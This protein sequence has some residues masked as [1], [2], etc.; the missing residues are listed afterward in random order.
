MKP[1]ILVLNSGNPSRIHHLKKISSLKEQYEILLIIDSKS[2]VLDQKPYAHHTFQIDMSRLDIE[3]DD[4]IQ[5]I[6]SIGTPKAILNLSEFMVPLQ[7]RLVTRFQLPGPDERMAKIGREKDIMRAF[8]EN[9]EIP[10]PRYKR[11]TSKNLSEVQNF[12][13]PVVVK[14]SMGGGSQLVQRCESWE[15]LQLMYPLLSESGKKAFAKEA[16]GFQAIQNEGELPF[17]V[18]ELIGGTVDYPSLFP[19]RVGEISVESVFDGNKVQV[20]A[21]HDKPLRSN[22][23]HFEEFIWSTPSRISEDLQKKA[24]HYVEKIHRALGKGA[25]VL[26]TEFRTLGE[27]LVILEFGVRM[28]GAAIY[29]SVL[30]STGIDMIEVLIG[31]GLGKELDVPEWKAIPTITHALWAEQQGRVSH[32]HGEKEV[33]KIPGYK[34]HDI[35]DHAGVE[36]VRAPLSTR[37]NGH[38]VFQSNLGFE[39]VESH[40]TDALSILWIELEGQRTKNPEINRI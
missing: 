9:L 10:I 20:L 6:E 14:P 15:E 24:A 4:L 17:I 21:I 19:Y 40:L 5:N 7:A 11:V 27:D 31:L 25:L 30:H 18:E 34:E 22:G 13:F 37:A 35:F 2:S 26:H 29:R 38:I 8:C 23:P 39:E 1:L 32:I 3:L 36:V 33:L 12:R 16:V 28:G